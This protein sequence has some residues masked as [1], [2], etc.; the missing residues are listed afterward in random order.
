VGLQGRDTINAASTIQHAFDNNYSFHGLCSQAA[1]R[2]ARRPL[3]SQI[4]S[5]C[6]ISK[7]TRKVGSYIPF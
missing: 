3:A 1:A 7:R 6:G 2:M 5:T 4:V